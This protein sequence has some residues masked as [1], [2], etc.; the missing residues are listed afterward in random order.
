MIAMLAAALAAW[1]FDPVPPLRR[2]DA[3]PRRDVRS[4]HTPIPWLVAVGGVITV[5]AVGGLRPG[6]LVV[7]AV[8][9]TATAGVLWTRHL[10][11]RGRARDAA[12]VAAGCA[13][14][15]REVRAG[16]GHTA[17]LMVVADDHPVFIP[18]AAALRVGGSVPESLRLAGA[19]PGRTGLIELARAWEVTARTGAELGPALNA[20]TSALRA[21]QVVAR[22]TAAELAAPRATGQVLG[23]LPIAG[24]VLGY[25]LGGD[26][27]GFLLTSTYGLLCLVGGV[28]LTCA[29]LV[30]SDRLSEQR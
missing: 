6:V 9:I 21:E 14:L 8:T 2:L 20:V 16:R 12:E 25:L 19:T 3:T 7:S 18:V 24:I 27:L 22:T 5:V 26:P 4:G 17:A 15:A 30:W 13:V 29:G 11:R 1:A 23:I 10:T 28:V